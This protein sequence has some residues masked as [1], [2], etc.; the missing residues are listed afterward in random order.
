M[1][2]NPALMKQILGF[3]P[4]DYFVEISQQLKSQQSV[5]L[6]EYENIL[7]EIQSSQEEMK[8]VL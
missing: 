2:Q 3:T 4:E 7:K 1:H 6:Q 8:D 5:F